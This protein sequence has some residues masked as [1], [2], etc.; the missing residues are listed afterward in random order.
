MNNVLRPLLAVAALFLMPAAT[1][2]AQGK[3]AEVKQDQ[4]KEAARE[5]ER[6]GTVVDRATGAPIAG[7]IVT[8][9]D[10]TV[11]TDAQGQLS[12]RRRHPAAAGPRRRL[13]PRDR[14]GKRCRAAD[15]QARAAACPRRSISPSTASARRSC[16]IRPST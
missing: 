15:H 3:D 12:R 10:K 8:A 2:Y 9:G 6:E 1:A 5:V 14:R 7:A 4:V 13:W 16:A 11:L